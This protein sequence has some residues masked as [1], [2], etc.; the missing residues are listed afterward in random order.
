M[1]QPFNGINLWM[2]VAGIIVILSGLH[3]LR[4]RIGEYKKSKDL[5]DK[6]VVWVRTIMHQWEIPALI[7]GIALIVK[8]FK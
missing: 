2:F 5:G 3:T 1:G 7:I 6:T 4:W 8:S